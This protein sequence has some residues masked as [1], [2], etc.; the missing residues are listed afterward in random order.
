MS[1]PVPRW[2]DRSRTM[3]M[4]ARTTAGRGGRVAADIAARLGDDAG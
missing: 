3:F 1:E 2:P 4:T